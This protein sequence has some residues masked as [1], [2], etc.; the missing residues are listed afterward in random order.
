MTVEGLL[1]RI[2]E[3]GGRVTWENGTLNLVRPFDP[4]WRKRI[5]DDL[6]PLLVE[7]R[8]GLLR[9]FRG[10]SDGDGGTVGT[11]E[12]VPNLTAPED[13]DGKH[14]RECDRTI[15]LGGCVTGEDVWRTCDMLM[16]PYW[17]EEFDQNG[18]RKQ[19]R[20]Q[21]AYRRQQRGSQ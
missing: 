5:V 16:C 6:L 17:R 15:Y 11:V 21:E 2:A 12:T 13:M 19:A 7:H 9:H 1:S 3:Y 20:N 14:C 18:W 8:S 10:S 4:Y